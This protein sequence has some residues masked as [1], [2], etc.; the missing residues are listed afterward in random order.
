[1]VFSR[2]RPIL[3][4]Y[5]VSSHMVKWWKGSKPADGQVR[6]ELIIVPRGRRNVEFLDALVV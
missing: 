4:R 1:M 6:R 3:A 2:S 5:D